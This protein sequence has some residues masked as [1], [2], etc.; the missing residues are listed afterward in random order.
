MKYEI[1]RIVYKNYYIYSLYDIVKI[2]FTNNNTIDLS[3]SKP[4]KLN[5]TTDI[6]SLNNKTDEIAI[7]D[8]EKYIDTDINIIG[9]ICSC[10]LMEHPIKG[11][12]KQI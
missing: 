4:L 2:A 10:Y 9:F 7:N 1:T 6:N 12:V 5:N 3:M 11:E 8:A